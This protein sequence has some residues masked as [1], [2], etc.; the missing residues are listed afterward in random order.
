LNWP[1]SRFTLP[2]LFGVALLVAGLI[3]LIPLRLLRI[4]LLVA[5]VA[6][7]SGKQYLT[8][9]EYLQ[10]WETHKDLFWQMVWRAPSI[11]PDTLVLMNDG[12]MKFYADNS[13]SAAL[14]WIYAPDNHSDQIDYVLFHPSTRFQNALPDIAP[15]LPVHFDYLAG[16]FNGNTSKT[17]SFEYLPPACL[18]LL[19][20]DTERLNRLISENSL[21]RYAARLTVPGLILDGPQAQLPAIYRPEPEH[22][23]CYY[24]Q[25]AD[26]A[27]QFGEWDK[28]AELGD[29]AK[30][31]EDHPFNPA[32]QLVF[33]EGYAH[34]GQ[35][36]RAVE[37]SKP[38]Y[39]YSNDIMGRVLCRL[40]RRIAEETGASAERTEALS[41]V[42]SLFGCS[43]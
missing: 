29:I 42:E 17:L 18:R 43:T 34:I 30:S 16:E 11:E 38:V 41:E 19:D 26:L 2:F 5:L 32:E 22:G 6:M 9:H 20:P 28:V 35:W 15:D 25:K 21:M 36:D 3:A 10:D 24:Y 12:G 14:N 37:L 8:S 33:I 23:F 1:A 4:V 27:R 40:W 31:F 39:D 7:S 13:L